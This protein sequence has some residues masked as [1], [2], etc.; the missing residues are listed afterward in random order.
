MIPAYAMECAGC[1]R[2]WVAVFDEGCRAPFGVECPGCH[3]PTGRSVAGPAE[4]DTVEEAHAYYAPDAKL[5]RAVRSLKAAKDRLY[6]QLQEVKDGT[7]TAD[8]IEDCL[9]QTS[10]VSGEGEAVEG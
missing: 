7:A 6:A 4:F 10:S 5:R 3:E 1:E 2:R 8:D 9:I